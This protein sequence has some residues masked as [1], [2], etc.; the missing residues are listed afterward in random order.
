MENLHLF[1]LGSAQDLLQNGSAILSHFIIFTGPKL[2]PKLLCNLLTGGNIN[3]RIS[4]C[5]GENLRDILTGLLDKIFDC[6]IAFLCPIGGSAEM[7]IVISIWSIKRHRNRINQSF[8][9][10]QNI[11]SVNQIGLSVGIDSDRYPLIFQ[12]A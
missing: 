1:L 9:F 6:L 8:Q 3:S 12:P 5:S 2:H 10:R 11:S 7:M 4:N